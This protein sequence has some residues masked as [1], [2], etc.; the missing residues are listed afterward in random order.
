M[1]FCAHQ[2]RSRSRAR[3]GTVHGFRDTDS[4]F[5]QILMSTMCAPSGGLLG[6]F[7]CCSPA[8]SVC[9]WAQS[10]SLASSRRAQSVMLRRAD[11]WTNGV[12]FHLRRPPTAP[13]SVAPCG[14][15]RG[16]M[17]PNVACVTL[18]ECKSTADHAPRTTAMV[19]LHVCGP[20]TQEGRVTGSFEVW[21]T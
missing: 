10:S 12:F 2:R 8:A 21:Q 16:N 7:S 1:I 13:T 20:Q 15:S 11:P 14:E 4:L 19:P 6:S 9:S 5:V 17:W 18:L 3:S